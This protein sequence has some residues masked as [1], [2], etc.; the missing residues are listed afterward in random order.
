MDINQNILFYLI[1]YLVG[2]IPFGLILAKVFAGIDIKSLGSGSIGATNVLRVVSEKD[3]AL[4]KKL[5][6][7]TLILDALKGVVVIVIAYL[8]SMPIETIWAIG[9]LSV[10]GHCYSPYLMFEGGKGVATSFGIFLITVPIPA[11]IGIAT[12][13]IVGKKTKISS[14]SSLLGILAVVIVALI[15]NPSNIEAINSFAPLLLI[16]FV[17]FYK[18]I[19][20]IIKLIKREEKAII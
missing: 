11:I 4:G 12:W 15:T 6:M 8:F 20:N 19:P 3:K 14:L 5:S 2:S 1:A 13:L 10:L 7:A 18:H 16:A 9:F 17:V